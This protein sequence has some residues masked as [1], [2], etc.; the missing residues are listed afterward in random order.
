MSDYSPLTRWR[1]NP[2]VRT[3]LFGLGVMLMLG[4]PLVGVIPGPGG[5]FVFAAGLAL[6]LQNSHWAKRQYVRFKR[7][8]PKAGRWA[9]WGLRRRS[10]KRR[11]AIAKGDPAARID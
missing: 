3:C 1:A 10:A 6:A 11:E 2:M 8:Q 9:D 7:W 4:S 5:V